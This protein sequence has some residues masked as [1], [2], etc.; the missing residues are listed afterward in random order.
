MK[1]EGGKPRA[2][3]TLPPPSPEDVWGVPTLI[4]QP[5]PFSLRRKIT[6]WLRLLPQGLT[7]GRVLRSDRA[8]DMGGAIPPRHPIGTQ[9]LHDAEHKMCDPWGG[10]HP[11]ALQF[12]LLRAH[13]VEQPDS[14]AEQYRGKM[15]L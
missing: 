3:R 4:T 8:P 9:S 10:D 6:R 14:V 13:L 15:N 7:S 5:K 12:D 1:T 11:R 2:S